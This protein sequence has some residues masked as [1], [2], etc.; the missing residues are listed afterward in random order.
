[1]NKSEIYSR[2]STRLAGINLME[3]NKSIAKPLHFRYTNFSNI[4]DRKK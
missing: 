2:I 3:T 1:M 4:F